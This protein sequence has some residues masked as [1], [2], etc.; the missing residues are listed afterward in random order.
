M[1]ALGQEEYPSLATLLQDVYQRRKNLL[2]VVELLGPSLTS[3]DTDKRCSAVQLLSSLLQKLVN[4]KLTD[5]EVE[6][7]C[8][9]YC[10]RLKDHYSIIP[11]AL[12]GL[13]ALASHQSMPGERA[14]I[15]IQTLFKEVHTQS[16]MQSGRYT[17]YS[18]L[19]SL[20]DK[21]MKDLKP[22]GSDLVFGFLQAMDGEK[23][24][25]L[26][27]EDLFEV[28][29]CYFPID[30]TPATDDPYGLT[31]DDLVLGL[32]R[33]LAAT[34][35]F[36][37]STCLEEYP[38]QQIKDYLQPLWQAIKRE[39]FQTVSSELEDAAL[40]ALSSIIKNLESSSQP[41]VVEF[42]TL[43]LDCVIKGETE[44]SFG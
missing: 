16:L 14:V 41:D 11:Q 25:R 33:C 17:V 39:V 27:A 5:R 30:F 37:P 28:T 13:Q 34:S 32:R 36:A 40:K 1:A 23:D 7:L 20:L 35:Q 12:L 3:T 24:P 29:S 26:F 22:V 10:D 9:F 43:F 6:L 18:L 44:L 8:E 21:N 31:K 19:A 4:Y 2:Q 38:P 42:K 15:L